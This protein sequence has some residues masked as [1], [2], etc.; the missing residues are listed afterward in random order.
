MKVLGF[1]SNSVQEKISIS[2]NQEMDKFKSKELNKKSCV[3]HDINIK[4][5]QD[6]ISKLNT[7]DGL[8]IDKIEQLRAELSSNT[9]T[10]EIL[11]ESMINYL[12][13]NSWHKEL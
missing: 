3:S 10:S 11:A 1:K 7:D 4:N 8:D 9:I 13:N 12:K 6:T 5:F 2:N